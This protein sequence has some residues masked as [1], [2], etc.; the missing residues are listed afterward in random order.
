MGIYYYG[1]S[2]D[3]LSKLYTHYDFNSDYYH[4]NVK[5][6]SHLTKIINDESLK[7]Y[8]D[9]IYK[10]LVRYNR[11]L[12]I[13]KA[14]FIEKLSILLKKMIKDNNCDYF[15]EVV[16]YLLNLK[17]FKRECRELYSYLKAI[18]YPEYLE[19]RQF[20]NLI[21]DI[22]YMSNYELDTRKYESPII[23]M[24]Q[25]FQIFCY[26]IYNDQSRRIL[27]DSFF[28]F[29]VCSDVIEYIHR[30]KAYGDDIIR[31]F[32]YI[33]DNIEEFKTFCK[34]NTKHFDDD[35]DFRRHLAEMIVNDFRK[36]NNNKHLE[37]R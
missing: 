17:M 27:T 12:M 29:M 8:H 34:L 19:D 18:Y 21:M 15:N 26:T 5:Y 13:D 35:Y 36:T 24:L 3:K 16:D 7:D 9:S 14:T 2:E 33:G 11:E 28:F 4:S 10:L 32:Y 23:N 20:Y 37:I 31:M 22:P 1:E 30:N 25:N 6:N